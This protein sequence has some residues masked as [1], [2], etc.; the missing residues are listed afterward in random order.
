MVHESDYS[1]GSHGTGVKPGGGEEW[2][3]VERHGALS[4]VEDEQFAPRQ[5]QQCNL[6]Q[7]T[8]RNVHIERD[9]I[10]DLYICTSGQSL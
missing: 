4:G 9:V 8:T 2:S 7:T 6:V 10:L 1:V 3:D 5:P